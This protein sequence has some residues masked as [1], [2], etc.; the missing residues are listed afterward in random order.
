MLGRTDFEGRIRRFIA[1]LRRA[2]GDEAEGLTQVDLRY[3]NGFAV[4]Q[5]PWQGC[6]SM[7]KGK[8][9]EVAGDGK[10]G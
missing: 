5:G 4:K 6:I 2:V 10:E 7:G 3:A 1:N 9:S 8:K